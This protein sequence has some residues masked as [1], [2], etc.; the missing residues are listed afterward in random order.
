MTARFSPLPLVAALVGHYDELVDDVRR[1]IGLRRHEACSAREVV[2]EVCLQLIEQ[3]AQGEIRSPLAFLRTMARR[4]A[5]DRHRVEAG[6]R[7]WVE[8]WA[9][10]PEDAQAEGSAHADPARIASGRQQL[11]LLVSA[12]HAMPLRCR[13]VFVMHKIHGIAQQEVAARL[14]IGIKTVEKHLR[15]GME[16]CWRALGQELAGRPGPLP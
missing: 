10:L 2:H 15:L 6:R 11:E 1:F 12:I 3:P 4:R 14:G 5:I 13:E 8:T 7:A 9:E 16:A